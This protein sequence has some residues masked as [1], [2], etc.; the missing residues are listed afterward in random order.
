MDAS[1]LSISRKKKMVKL[2]S[3]LG[4]G[5]LTPSPTSVTNECDMK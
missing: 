3:I 2:W 5:R 1:A 4:N